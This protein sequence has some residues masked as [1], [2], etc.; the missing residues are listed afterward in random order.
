[1]KT[2]ASI[3]LWGGIDYGGEASRMT[4]A[5]HRGI[6]R[7]DSLGYLPN[8]L[9]EVTSISDLFPAVSRLFTGYEATERSFKDNARVANI[10]HIATHGFFQ[11]DEKHKRTSAMYNTGLFFADANIAWTAD[12]IQQIDPDNDGILRAIEIA[13]MDL[14][15]CGLVVLSACE[16]GL[17]YI[18]GNEGVYGLQRA[19]RQA[20]AGSIIMSLWKVEDAPTEMLMSAFYGY[21]EQGLGYEEAFKKS[22]AELRQKWPRPKDWGAFVLL[23]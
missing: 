10:I 15:R 17:G 14:S 8:T 9:T 23:N 20:G 18:D 16:T 11:E 7:G 5:S 13:Q 4:A 6:Q 19:F 22:R 2:V 21:V 12:S 1:M 3:M